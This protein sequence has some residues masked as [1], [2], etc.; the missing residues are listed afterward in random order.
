[1]SSFDNK[2]QVLLSQIYEAEEKTST[3]ARIII[4]P[5]CRGQLQCT[6]FFL[7]PNLDFVYGKRLSAKHSTNDW[8]NL[9]QRVEQIFRV[10]CI[11]SVW[12]CGKD[13]GG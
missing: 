12:T 1:M 7:I 3:H 11:D 13:R 8:I 4:I 2:L 6:F 10:C 9:Y 5:Y